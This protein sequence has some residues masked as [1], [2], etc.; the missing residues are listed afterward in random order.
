MEPSSSAATRAEN[1]IAGRTVEALATL[2]T[3]PNNDIGLT[4]L[5]QFL[6]PEECAHLIALGGLQLEPSRVITDGE[7]V[8]APQ[9]TSE[10]CY[11]IK[12]CDPI[13]RQVE[14]KVAAHLGRSVDHLEPLQLVRYLPGQEFQAHFDSFSEEYVASI[15][16]QRQFTVFCYLAD[17]LQGG[18]TE[19]PRLGASFQPI[20]GNALVWE[21]TSSC[22]GAAHPNALHKGNPPTGDSTKF[23]L[24]AWC[25]FNTLTAAAAA[26]E[27]A[28][29]ATS[30]N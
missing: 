18:S 24:N 4:Y 8:V 11:L 16:N 9:R 21:N 28:A 25:C 15:Q 5:P 10:S 1:P 12:S 3:I 20:A 30:N 14:H 22:N 13:V 23:A 19:F 27:V 26:T 17:C 2:A 29:A 6:T 7:S